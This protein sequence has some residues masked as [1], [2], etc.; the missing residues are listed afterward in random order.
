MY[1]PLILGGRKT[2]ET[3]LSHHRREPFGVITPGDRL[4]FKVS[5]GPFFARAVA[6]RV[7]MTDRLTPEMIEG[8]RKR[9]DHEIHGTADYWKTRRDCRFATLIWLRE[10]AAT[11]AHPRYRYQHMCAWYTLPDSA[12]PLPGGLPPELAGFEVTLTGGAIRNRYVRLTADQVKE[13]SGHDGRQFHLK[14]AGGAETRTDL[15]RSIFRWRGWG[16]WFASQEV[17]PGDRLRFTPQAP[18]TYHVAVVRE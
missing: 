13:L 17:K 16:K 12:D 11:T 5:S 6:D 1:E 4:Y 9:H 15:Y 18:G 3:R 2:I 8:F 14:L 7:W 10:V